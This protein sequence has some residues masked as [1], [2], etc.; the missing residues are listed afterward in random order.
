MMVAAWIRK[1]RPVPLCGCYGWVHRRIRI[2]V[3]LDRADSPVEVEGSNLC[4]VPLVVREIKE[5]RWCL[6]LPR[7]PV[8]HRERQ[9]SLSQRGPVD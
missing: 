6:L 1:A 9:K 2:W 8:E 7:L 4:I 5:V 3:A